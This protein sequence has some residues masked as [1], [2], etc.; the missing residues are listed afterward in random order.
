MVPLHLQHQ[1]NPVVLLPNGDGSLVQGRPHQIVK[2]K[3]RA[4][5]QQGPSLKRLMNRAHSSYWAA[6]S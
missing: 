3:K 4:K 1:M 6:S 5:I 2:K